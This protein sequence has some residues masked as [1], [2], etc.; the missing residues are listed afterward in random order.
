MMSPGRFSE[1]LPAIESVGAGQ[2]IDSCLSSAEW[3]CVRTHPKREHLAAVQ[4]RH[5]P[6]LAV[7]LPRIRYRR[8]TRQGP[9]WTTE[10]LFPN[11][12]FARFDL[13][14]CLRRVRH[15]RGVREVVHFGDKWP[16]VPASTIRELQ[17]LMGTEELRVIP[18]D[19]SPGDQ[20][21]IAERA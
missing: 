12:L 7:F 3:F 8:P 6:D 9:V 2:S 1:S 11:Y 4:L 10:A 17:R 21:Q 5:D 20:V 16:T 18:A 15:A 13:A 14:L 19:F